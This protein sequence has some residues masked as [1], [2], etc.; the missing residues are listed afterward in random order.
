[1][2]H[3][4][5]APE[6]DA[7]IAD[8]VAYTAERWGVDQVRKY[9]A[10]LEQR[11]DDF[12]QGKVHSKPQNALVSGLKIARYEHHYIFG[13]ERPQQPM[14]ILAIFHE[15]MDVIERLKHRLT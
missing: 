11:L 3:Y 10:G 14:L 9:M 7:D 1:M 13:L 4:E 6:V 12:A 8:I 5:K 2:A 15:R